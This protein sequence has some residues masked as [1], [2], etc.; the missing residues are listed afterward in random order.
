MLAFVCCGCPEFRCCL[1]GDKKPT[2]KL[3]IQTHYAPETPS[4]K[5]AQEYFDDVKVMSNGE[6]ELSRSSRLFP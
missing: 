3:R 6:I 2:T 1:C 4:G 5:L